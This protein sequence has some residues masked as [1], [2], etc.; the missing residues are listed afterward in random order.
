MGRSFLDVLKGKP[1]T[2][3][4]PKNGAEFFLEGP[5]D[6]PYDEK[7]VMFERNNGLLFR[8]INNETHQ[9]AFYNDTKKYEFHVTTTF[10]SQSSDL[11]ALGKTSLVEIPDGHVAKI[12]VYPGKT[13]PFVQGN[14]V[15][16]ET[17][18]DGKLLTNEYRD[19]VREEKKE[20]RHRK[21][22]AK[23]AAKRGEDP[24]QFEEEE[25]RDN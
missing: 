10:S 17:S 14:M 2:N 6:F 11:V 24:N 7:K 19:Q 16:F 20:E 8:L 25:V 3:K 15:G 1:N 12:I 4:Q 9:W 18:V 22:E 13:E 21:R 23:K 5:T